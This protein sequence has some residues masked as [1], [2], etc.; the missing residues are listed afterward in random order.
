[1]TEVTVK[2]PS[3]ASGTSRVT[4]TSGSQ[5]GSD[6]VVSVASA[7]AAPASTRT[8]T[9]TSTLAGKPA[10][11]TS[12]SVASACSRTSTRSLPAKRPVTDARLGV[13]VRHRTRRTVA[14][15]ARVTERSSTTVSASCTTAASSFPDPSG[16]R[17]ARSASRGRRRLSHRTRGPG[18]A[19]QEMPRVGPPPGS[20][21]AYMPPMPPRPLLLVAAPGIPVRGPS[22]ASAHVRGVA[23]ALRPVAIVAARAHDHRGAH[24]EVEAPIVETGVPGWPA[25]LDRYREYTEVWTARRVA[26][27]AVRL[28]PTLLWER[29]TL[30]SDAGWK[31]HAATGAPWILEVNAAPVAER[32]RYETVRLRGWAED[33]ERDVLTAAPRVLAV[34]AW[35]AEWLRSLG[36]RDVRHVPNGVAPHVGDREGARRALGLDGKVVV[37]FLGSMKP[38]HGVERLPALL[39]A[40]PDTVGLLVGDGPVRVTHPRLVHAGQVSEARVADLVAAMDVG[41]APYGPDA[42]PW[43]CP[44]KVLAYRAQGTPIVATDVGDCRALVGNAG[45]IVPTDAP[46]GDLVDAVRAW[47]GR[48]PAAWTRTWDDVVAE[49][50]GD[51]HR[52]VALD[53]PEH[54]TGA[55]G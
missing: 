11:S 42:P 8:C 47:R 44:L 51:V 31:V 33:W 36:C 41:L 38:W 12:W 55:A 43:F 6:R 53:V 46:L 52:A 25:W 40:M 35:L 49:G 50:L 15:S 13:A 3:A 7:A 24:G 32:L 39:D 34:S 37:G 1:M 5:V 20:P 29:H 27:A 26:R 23:G 48:R 16:E 14:M 28:D 30:F 4:I 17:Q 18:G 19:C 21:T 10:R 9:V 2:P 45:T 22:G 54:A